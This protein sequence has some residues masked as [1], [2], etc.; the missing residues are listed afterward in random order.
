MA[1]IVD[2]GPW[3]I[4]IRALAVGGPRA[5][6]QLDEFVREQAWDSLAISNEACT[7]PACN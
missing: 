1:Y 5:M 7:G 4:G 3:L 2:T 6:E